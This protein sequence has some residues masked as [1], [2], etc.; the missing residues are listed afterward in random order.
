[1]QKRSKKA[2][3]ATC[4]TQEKYTYRKLLLLLLLTEHQNGVH[5]IQIYNLQKMVVSHDNSEEN[6]G[7]MCAALHLP[8]HGS[9]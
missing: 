7:L 5:Y 4:D 9:G 1:M 8:C 6:D 2:L 3:Q